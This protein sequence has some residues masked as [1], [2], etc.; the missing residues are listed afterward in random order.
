MCTV[1]RGE[2]IRLTEPKKNDPRQTYTHIS[3]S[4]NPQNDHDD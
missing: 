3:A 2:R 4:A 1:G